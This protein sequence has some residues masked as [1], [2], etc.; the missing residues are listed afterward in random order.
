MNIAVLFGGI[1]TERNVSLV[2]GKAVCEALRTKGYNV[3]PIDPAFGADALHK[4]ESLL[5]AE[6]TAQNF[7]TLEELSAFS[8]RS[9]LDCINSPLF[10]DIDCAFIVLH[11][12]YGEDGVIQSLLDLRGIP[13]TGSGARA[14][15]VAMD[16]LTSKTLFAA[17]GI[18]TPRWEM[19]QPADADDMDFLTDIRKNFGKRIVIKPSDQGSTVGLTIVKDGS[20]EDIAA[21]IRNAAVYSP[22]I[23]AERYVEGR[24]L[25]VAILDQEALPVIE[26]VTDDGFYDYQHKYT[27][28]QTNYICPAK[29]S[30]DI[31]GFTQNMALSAYNAI[32]C[33]CFARVDFILDAEGQPFCLEVNT[34]PGFSSTSLVPMA[35]KATG[36]EFADLCEKLINLA[37]NITEE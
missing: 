29:L 34:I 5:N 12:K 4:T 36:I 10:D 33:K 28:G 26:I 13:Y 21:G 16:K 3:I 24:E 22:N 14:S 7:A 31:A 11:G 8:P 1:S 32:G 25:T 20:L 17:N 23:L 37:C 2:G 15:A 35:A 18:I 27:K 9:Y 30:E 6:L 19:L